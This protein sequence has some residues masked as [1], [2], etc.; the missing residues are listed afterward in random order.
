M[1]KYKELE[2]EII[3]FQQEDVIMSS[4]PELRCEVDGEVVCLGD[5]TCQINQ[6]T[7]NTPHTHLI[8]NKSFQDGVSGYHLKR[9]LVTPSFLYG[10]IEKQGFG[11]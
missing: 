5:G 1:E 11:L 6:L 3:E 2:M 7:S 9:Q 4:C 8:H 10:I